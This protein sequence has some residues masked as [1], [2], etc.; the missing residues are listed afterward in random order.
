MKIAIIGAGNVG[1]ALGTGWRKAGHEVTLGV[2][3]PAGSRA[4]ELEQQGFAI[5]P[6]KDAAARAEVIVLAVPWGA[7]RATLESLG[8]LAGKIMIDATNPLT[9]DMS[10]AHTD[11]AGE[12]VA[13]L[14]PGARV[15][16]AFNTT[17]AN[18][19]LDSRYASGKLVMLVA[20]DDPAAKAGVISLANDLGFE[21]VDTGPLAMS[22]Y[23]EPM[24]MVWIK[25]ALAQ[26]LGRNFG[27]ALLRK[28]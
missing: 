23:L 11:S 25:L 18:N 2:R 4:T 3:D 5:A 12:T 1:R 6:P 26:K 20:G 15:V 21:A 16:K 17:G 27:F 8:A 13:R 24:A 28:G 22:R 19:M 14:A 9:S 10:L 7:V